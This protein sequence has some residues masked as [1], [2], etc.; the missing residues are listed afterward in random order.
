MWEFQTIIRLI[1]KRE[2]KTDH[3]ELYRLF[4][5]VK[6][7][8]GILTAIIFLANE[9]FYEYIEHLPSVHL[10]EINLLL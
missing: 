8:L 9:F 4:F 10:R 1:V 7:K 6:D 2:S 5:K 3:T